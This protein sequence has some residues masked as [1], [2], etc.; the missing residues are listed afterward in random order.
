LIRGTENLV[1][2]VLIARISGFERDDPHAVTPQVDL[3]RHFN[4]GLLRG[5][6]GARQVS[7]F[8]RAG[9]FAQ[10]PAPPFKWCFDS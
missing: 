6:E 7:F 2:L 9:G 1:P 5:P 4:A 8:K 3:D 10:M